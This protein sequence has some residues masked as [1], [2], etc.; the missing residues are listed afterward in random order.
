[1][2]LKFAGPKIPERVGSIPRQILLLYH[3]KG[4][5]RE[6]PTPGEIDF[7]PRCSLSTD[8][9][10]SSPLNEQ[11]HSAALTT[12]SLLHCSGDQIVRHMTVCRHA[13]NAIIIRRS[14]ETD[15][16][17]LSYVGTLLSAQQSVVA[18]GSSMGPFKHAQIREPESAL[19]NGDTV[20]MFPLVLH[21][22]IQPSAHQLSP[23]RC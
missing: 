5:S 21:L 22:F 11:V 3:R 6:S 1:M 16:L 9:L 15:R 12:T 23:P 8:L 4:A 19:E 18:P 13:T 14:D 10:L 7:V 17:H 2:R 20:H